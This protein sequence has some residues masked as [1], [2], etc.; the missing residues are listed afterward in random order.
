[1]I[2]AIK[3]ML[4]KD[5]AVASNIGKWLI[6]IALSGMALYFLFL[7]IVAILVAIFVVP[8][9]R[10]LIERLRQHPDMKHPSM[11]KKCMT[12]LKESIIVMFPDQLKNI[13]FM[14]DAHQQILNTC[15]QA[16][17]ASS[18]G[19]FYNQVVENANSVDEHASPAYDS[20]HASAHAAA[21]AAKHNLTSHSVPVGHGAMHTAGS[22]NADGLGVHS[23]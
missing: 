10:T 11:K 3:K 9:M 19:D 20:H 8:K 1:M 17:N 5:F 16:T 14:K 13:K 23:L 7:V 18:I 12:V 21:E 15:N 22:A 2:K 4:E 6:I